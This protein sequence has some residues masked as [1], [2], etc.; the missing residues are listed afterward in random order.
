MSPF[1]GRQGI[2][3]SLKR[4]IRL[5]RNDV[6]SVGTRDLVFWT[7][8]KILN[9]IKNPEWPGFSISVLNRFSQVT[10]TKTFEL[11]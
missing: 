6:V 10:L 8:N 7:S 3:S 5:S 1:S 4:Y 9:H 2:V 11:Y